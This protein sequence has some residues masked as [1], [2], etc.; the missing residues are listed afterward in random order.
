MTEGFVA[1]GEV[2]SCMQYSFT[3]FYLRGTVNK[4]VLL[5]KYKVL[6]NF[7]FLTNSPFPYCILF[8]NG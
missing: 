2:Q 6:L 3:V 7:L 8:L 4:K 5:F 1:P